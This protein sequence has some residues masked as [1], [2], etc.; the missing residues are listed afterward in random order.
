M[1]AWV[2]L[3]RTR[4]TVLKFTVSTSFWKKRFPGYFLYWIVENVTVKH[5]V[6][7]SYWTIYQGCELWRELNFIAFAVFL[8]DDGDSVTDW[9]KLL[10]QVTSF[11]FINMT[12]A[13]IKWQDKNIS[14][15]T[16]CL[17]PPNLAD[18]LLIL[19]SSYP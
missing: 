14:S 12:R 9:Q 7:W 13:K 19:S 2:S 1:G 3:W 17:W 16:Q 10:V 11:G 15:L 5:F 18:W 4:L 6:T 8:P